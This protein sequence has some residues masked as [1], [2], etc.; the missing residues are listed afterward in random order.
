MNYQQHGHSYGQ[1]QGGQVQAGQVPHRY[2]PQHKTKASHKLWVKE[3]MEKL[4]GSPI[5][6]EYLKK[7]TNLINVA[8]PK[9]IE[10]TEAE[11]FV[12]VAASLTKSL[13]KYDDMF[14]FL[15]KIV[16]GPTSTIKSQVDSIIKLY[17]TEEAVAQHRKSSQKKTDSSKVA[18]KATSSS[19]PL[20]P[21]GKA[22]VSKSSTATKPPKK[23][24]KSQKVQ[25]TQKSG[26]R[27]ASTTQTGTTTAKQPKSISSIKRTKKAKKLN[28]DQIEEKDCLQIG[29]VDEEK[30]EDEITGWFT[31]DSNFNSTA[32]DTVLFPSTVF[33]EKIDCV[34]IKLFGDAAQ[35]E[36]EL[37][38]C[39]VILCWFKTTKPFVLSFSTSMKGIPPK[40]TRRNGS[41]VRPILDVKGESK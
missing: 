12:E 39:F 37:G 3:S 40:H 22:S 9:H 31:K 35:Y 23:S 17:H 24:Q 8:F 18:L 11:S 26:K 20:K 16:K 25:K 32:V 21:K 19:S 38:L 30:E 27:K 15:K 2:P 29:G 36:R 14:K 10:K 41:T 5:H 1:V 34:A 7:I 13:D 33:L 28:D 4:T 6:P